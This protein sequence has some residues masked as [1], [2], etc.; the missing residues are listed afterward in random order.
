MSLKQFLSLS[1]QIALCFISVSCGVYEKQISR[2]ASEIPIKIKVGY[3]YDSRFPDM[4]DALM[5]ESLSY[6]IE[7]IACEFGISNIEF[8][9]IKRVSIDD[10]FRKHLPKTNRFNRLNPFNTESVSF[11]ISEEQEKRFYKYY[12]MDSLRGFLD[13]S[14]SNVTKVEFHRILMKTWLNKAAIY[15]N[16]K[17]DGILVFTKESL[18]YQTYSSWRMLLEEQNEFD[19]IF[20]NTLVFYDNLTQPFPHTIFKKASAGAVGVPSK[21]SPAFY[22]GCFTVSYIPYSGIDYFSDFSE[23]EVNTAK[24]IGIYYIAH[25]FGH[26]AF[27]LPDVYNHQLHC[28]MNTPKENLS[29]EKAVYEFEKH[30]SPCPM[31]R[32]NLIE[33][34]RN[35]IR[36]SNNF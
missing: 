27:R 26:A 4:S 33:G 19:L 30:K 31:C 2:K 20:H 15:T 18:F 1:I 10:F 23:D 12:D 11:E 21:N 24:Y 29:Q 32:K 6:A 34:K 8:S 35:L 14:K 36:M 3:L 13:E 7:A 9:Q 16:Y 22:K 25:E 28:L 17:I 5:K